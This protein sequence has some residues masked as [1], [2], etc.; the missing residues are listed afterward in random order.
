V[1]E[2]AALQLQVN[3]LNVFN[4][5]N[6]ELNANSLNVSPANRASA[7]KLLAIRPG[8]EGFGARTINVEARLDF[9]WTTI[10]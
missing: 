9:D 3:A 5:E 2:R 10:R 8:I 1:A 7:G 4:I 6:F